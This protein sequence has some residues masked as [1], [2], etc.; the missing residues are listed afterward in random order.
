MRKWL[1]LMV[2]IA[3]LL[4]PQLI[5]AQAKVGTA[6]AQFLELGVSARAIGMGDAFLAISDDAS[7][8]YYNP[9]GLTQ[10]AEREAVFTHVSY[11]ADINYD[12]AGLAYPTAKFGGV[13][14]V[15]FYMLN[16]GD[17]D[18]TH[19]E[20][21][22]DNYSTGQTF[23]AK[24]YALSLSYARS[25]TDRF[26]VGMTLKLI[27]E[28][29]D[30]ERAIGWAAD[31]GT[32]YDTGFKGFKIAMVV[33]N[34]GPDIKFIE[35]E[36]PLPMNFKFGG[37]FDIYRAENHMATFS[38]EGSHP[39]DNLEKFNAG[40]EYWFRDMFSLRFGNHFEYD[41]GGISAGCGLK[42]YVSERQLKFDYGYHDME[43]LEGFHRFSVGLSF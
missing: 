30:T 40:V 31:M 17:M 43:I 11:L 1:I 9:A 10:I 12:F 20:G 41:T 8:V 25:L 23:T 15:G 19:Y 37:V 7:A 4:I 22:E 38:V 24:D 34:F 14:G 29:L 2:G 26:S 36:C 6:G 33:S 3:V 32:L 18:V 21:Y 28:L 39:N 42:L 13:W 5:W 16:A 35:E 27:E